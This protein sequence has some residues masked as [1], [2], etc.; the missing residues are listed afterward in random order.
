M[1]AVN[2]RDQFDEYW[3]LTLKHKTEM[4]VASDVACNV[5]VS[6]PA[7]VLCKFGADHRTGDSVV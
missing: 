7:N 3:S 1:R 2:G 6:L 5:S 4:Y